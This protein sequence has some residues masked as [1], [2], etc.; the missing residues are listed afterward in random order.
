MTEV[1]M[2]ESGQLESPLKEPRDCSEGTVLGTGQSGTSNLGLP[3]HPHRSFPNTVATAV[4]SKGKNRVEGRGHISLIC[5][6]RI[7][8]RDKIISSDMELP[9]SSCTREQWGN[10]KMNQQK[11]WQFPKFYELVV[12]LRVNSK[13]AKCKSPLLVIGQRDW[14]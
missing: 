1:N 9:S 12:F 7:S 4:R 2:L 5:I 6:L 8:L 14:Q 13:F 10:K 3:T 11:E